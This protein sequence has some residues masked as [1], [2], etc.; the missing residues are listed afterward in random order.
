MESLTSSIYIVHDK[1]FYKF[2]CFYYI[3][4]EILKKNFDTQVSKIIMIFGVDKSSF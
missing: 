3:V 1:D 2:A 4:L